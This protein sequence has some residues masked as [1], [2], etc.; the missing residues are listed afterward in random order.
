MSIRPAL[1]RDVDV[2]DGETLRGQCSI[3][4]ACTGG[5]VWDGIQDQIHGTFGIMTIHYD[6]CPPKSSFLPRSIVLNRPLNF[7][8]LEVLK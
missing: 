6:D 1:G 2:D 8:E 5:T 4:H 3:L 7:K